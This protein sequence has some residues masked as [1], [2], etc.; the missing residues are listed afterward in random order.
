MKKFLLLSLASIFV[1]AAGC[2]KQD[3]KHAVA[4]NGIEAIAFTDEPSVRGGAEED[5]HLQTIYF[6]F[7]KSDL[8]NDST[9]TLK[10]NA[11]YLISN[12]NLKVALEGHT[13]NRG[14]IEYNLA[15]GQR[16]ALKVKEY[17]AL[18]GIEPNRIATISYGKE[19]PVDPNDDETAWAKNRRAETKTL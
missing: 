10:E 6:A 8:T 11:S 17:Y 7:D 12:P 5:S 1:F 3:I 13:D 4:D 2:K 16:R 19:K 15:L 18:L 14:T 9:N